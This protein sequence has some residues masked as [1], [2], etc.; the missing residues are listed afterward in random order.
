MCNCKKPKNLKA[1][2][3]PTPTPEPINTPD[4]LHSKELNEWYSSLSEIELKE[5]ED[6]KIE[7]DGESIG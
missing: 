3:V 1:E 2:V 6:L 7:H 4:E 5:I